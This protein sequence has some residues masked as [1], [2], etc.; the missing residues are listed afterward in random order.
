MITFLFTLLVVGFVVGAIARFLLPG[1]DPLGCL[2]TALLGI[3]GSFVGGLLADA[4]FGHPGRGASL[5]PVGLV[6]SVA[7]AMILLL[8]LR[9]IRGGGR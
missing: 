6:G 9:L 1:R 8:L 7:G 3:T 4:L 5:H 2:G